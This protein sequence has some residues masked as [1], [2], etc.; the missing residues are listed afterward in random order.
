MKNLR[1][2]EDY[3][4]K[5]AFNAYFRRFGKFAYV[6]SQTVEFIE[7]KGKDYIILSNVNGTLATYRIR[8]DGSLKFQKRSPFS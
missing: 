7:D 5:R 2:E 1:N 6:P 8:E 4:K 3:I